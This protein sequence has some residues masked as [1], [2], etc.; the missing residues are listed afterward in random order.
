MTAFTIDRRRFLG[1][2]GGLSGLLF[3]FPH[4][5]I[6][7]ISASSMPTIAVVEGKNLAKAISRAIEL[8]GG[9][10]RFIKRGDVV[11]LKPNMGFPN[12]PRYG[13]TT[14]P[15]VLREVALL[16]IQAGA[17]KILVCDNPVRKPNICLK[18]NGIKE[19][20]KD[21]PSTHIFT[22]TGERFFVERR[23]K[24]GEHLKSTRIAKTLLEVDVFINIPTAK[25][26]N[27]TEVSFS[28][29]NM[30][31]LIEN[32]L[33]LH[34]MYN[35]HRSIADL[36]LIR[37]PDLVLMDATRSLISGGPAG[38]GEIVKTD[39]VVAGSDPVAVDSWMVESMKWN[40][41]T[42]KARE[43]KH[44]F[45]AYKRGIGEIDLDR[46]NILKE[47]VI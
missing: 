14:S 30:M 20:L 36:N 29:K 4:A 28:L 42:F 9:V 24:G 38:P 34:G 1:M 27:S 7:G 17:S 3:F 35:L 37:K 43:I 44:I 41:K 45:E 26:H 33:I 18:A 13:A 16:S 25:S 31:G 19:A 46:I 22:L 32:R 6:D 5:T 39:T 21:L 40:D 10:K 47:R 11:L 12:P 23:I 15:E 2:A 8:L